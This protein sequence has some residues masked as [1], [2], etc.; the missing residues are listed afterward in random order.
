MSGLF[1]VARNSSFTYKGKPAKVQQVCQDLG[2]RYVLEGSVRR[3][4]NRVRIT[5]QLI[6][7][8]SGG[9][10]WV[11]RYDRDLTDIFGVQDEIAHSIVDALKV[12]LLPQESSAIR[13]VPT[14][15]V[16]AYQFYLRGR[17]FFNRHSKR[18]YD[19]ARRMFA[20][21]IDIDP[22]YAR[23]YAGIA[24]CDAFRFLNY[25]FEASI[26]DVRAAS[27][28]A[29]ELDPE[30]A[31]V[32]ASRGLALSINSDHAEAERGFQHALRLDPDLFEGHL[33]YAQACVRQG[34]HQDAAAHYERAAEVAPDDYQALILA[35]C[36]Y[37]A[38][39]RESEAISADFRGFERATRK[40]EWDPE[41]ARAA[42][43]GA[44]ALIDP[45]DFLVLYN[46][47]CV[48][49]L[50]GAHDQAIELLARAIPHAHH[51]L[52][53]WMHNGSDLDVLRG[54]FRFRALLHRAAAP[55]G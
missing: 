24:D 4:M 12:G 36:A 13:K 14:R 23:A 38:L 39:G 1:V 45:D 33:F 8:P 46:L 29:L 21:A 48:Q 17:Q 49:V 2:V 30:L 28:R 6:D 18:S 16:E 22:D 7:G 27:A 31:E 25:D 44:A 15:N 20:R 37:R 32:H 5:A 43:M 11:E 35:G 54:D 51:E 3:V 10:L 40:L 47:A 42:F 55:A 34:K 53:A 52:V 41:D 26:D 50:L 19:V 9:H